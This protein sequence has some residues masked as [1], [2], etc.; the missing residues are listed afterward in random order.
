M[1]VLL[2]LLV[3]PDA[4]SSASIWHFSAHSSAAMIW[5]GSLPLLL[6]LLHRG[7]ECCESRM[8]KKGDIVL[9][10]PRLVPAPPPPPTP[11]TPQPA[12]LRPWLG[13][14]ARLFHGVRTVGAM[15]NEHS[16]RQGTSGMPRPEP[17]SFEKHQPGSQGVAGECRRARAKGKQ[18]WLEP[19]QGLELGAGFGLGP[20]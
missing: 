12:P 1:C 10:H 7:G 19:N 18:L 2:H 5:T 16:V 17:A 4:S 3:L 6:L 8:A 11:P 14:W 9:G 20:S 15:L 13:P